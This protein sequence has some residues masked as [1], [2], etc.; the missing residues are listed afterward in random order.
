MGSRHRSGRETSYGSAETFSEQKARSAD[1]AAFAPSPSRAFCAGS[2]KL[3][4]LP[5]LSDQIIYLSRG[6]RAGARDPST[7]SAPPKSINYLCLSAALC[8]EHVEQVK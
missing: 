1:I 7:L 5:P 4:S 2:W 6:A 8:V 3:R